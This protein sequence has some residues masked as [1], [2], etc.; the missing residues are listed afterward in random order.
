MDLIRRKINATPYDTPFNIT[1]SSSSHPENVA[2]N[3]LM[4]QMTTI[5]EK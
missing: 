1:L 2:L 5:I 3:A 4:I